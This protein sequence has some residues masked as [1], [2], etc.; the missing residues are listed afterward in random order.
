MF[1]VVIEFVNH[2]SPK[3]QGEAVVNYCESLAKLDLA[4]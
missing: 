3:K 4:A 2:I 1:I